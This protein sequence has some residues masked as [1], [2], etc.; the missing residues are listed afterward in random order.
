MHWPQI[1]YITIT[2]LTLLITTICDYTLPR[3]PELPIHL[4]VSA[5]YIWLLWMG[6]FF[7]G[8]Q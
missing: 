1:I 2:A 7:G 4:V 3:K 5:F 6:G 8:A